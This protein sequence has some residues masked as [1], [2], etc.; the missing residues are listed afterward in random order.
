MTRVPT[1]PA[2]QTTTWPRVRIWR[3]PLQGGEL[4]PGQRGGNEGDRDPG[5]GDAEDLEHHRRELAPGG[6]SA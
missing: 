5:E 1:L 3:R 2:P 6:S 4:R